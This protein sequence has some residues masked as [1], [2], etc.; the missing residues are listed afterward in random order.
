MEPNQKKSWGK[1]IAMGGIAM[2]ALAGVGVPGALSQDYGGMQRFGMGGG[3]SVMHMQANFRD[4]MGLIEREFGRFLE[5]I[6]ATPQQEKKLEEIRDKLLFDVSVIMFGFLD[7]LE[8]FDKLPTFDREA[9][10]K[11]RAEI[12]A[13]FDNASRKLTRALLDVRDVLTPEQRAKLAE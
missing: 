5:E 10:E 9:A 3:G 12:V 13:V 4:G 7:T 2:V 11:L 8:D 1:R 6:D